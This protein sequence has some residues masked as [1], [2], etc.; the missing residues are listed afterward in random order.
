[1][2]TERERVNSVCGNHSRHASRSVFRV[3]N[4]IKDGIGE[5]FRDMV[6]I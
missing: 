3:V 1:M 2:I 5:I 6:E 4:K